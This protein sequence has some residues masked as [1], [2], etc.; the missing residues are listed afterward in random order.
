MLE[1]NHS[2]APTSS[3]ASSLPGAGILAP[4]SSL[5]LSLA[6]FRCST[7]EQQ[8]SKKTLE[9]HWRPSLPAITSISASSVLRMSTIFEHRNQ[10]SARRSALLLHVLNQTCLTVQGR[11]M[12][13]LNAILEVIRILRRHVLK[14]MCDSVQ[15]HQLLHLTSS[16]S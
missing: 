5:S 3:K 16:D 10:D 9:Y 13:E 8:H 1:Y 12:R 15:T 4:I 7:C 6:G 14:P 2:D 11:G